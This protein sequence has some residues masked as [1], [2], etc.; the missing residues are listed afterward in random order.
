LR[1]G[2]GAG[3][4]RLG[5]SWKIDA[6]NNLQHRIRRPSQGGLVDFKY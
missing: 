4:P 5:D 2:W 3:K 1:P 6:K